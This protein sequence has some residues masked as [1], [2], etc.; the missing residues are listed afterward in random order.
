[1]HISIVFL[2]A[3]RVLKIKRAIKLPF[4][5]NSTLEK[6]RL[7]CEEE[8]AVNARHAPQ[9]Y[10]RV[11]AITRGANGLELGGSGPVVEWAV[12]MARFDENRTLDHLAAAHAV[13]PGAADALAET[14]RSSHANAPIVADAPWP[15]SI[16]TI[17]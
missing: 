17:I 5:D 9:I 6:R 3:D 15:N 7:C 10:R 2:A 13:P 12:E 14:M 11:V 16:A 4:L 1:T 8:L